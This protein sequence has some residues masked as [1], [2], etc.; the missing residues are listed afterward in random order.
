MAFQLFFYKLNLSSRGCFFGKL[1]IKIG[2]CVY[3][4]TGAATDSDLIEKAYRAKIEYLYEE[5]D[6]TYNQSKYFALVKWYSRPEELPKKNLQDEDFVFD[7]ERE[8]VVDSR[9]DNRIDIETIIKKCS[10]IEGGNFEE[11]KQRPDMYVCRYKLVRH[12]GKSQ[13]FDLLPLNAIISDYNKN[14]KTPKRTVSRAGSELKTPKLKIKR[15]SGEDFEIVD[16]IQSPS[17]KPC[18]IK[19]EDVS[20]SM[21]SLQVSP[22]KIVNNSVQKINRNRLDEDYYYVSPSKK[23]KNDYYEPNGNYL[24]IEEVNVDSPLIHRPS[25]AAKRRLTMESNAD[26]DYTITSEEVL[27]IKVRISQKENTQRRSSIEKTTPLRRSTRIKSVLIESEV[28]QE[29]E[30]NV[31]PRKNKQIDLGTPRQIVSRRKSILKTPGA[32]D[33]CT[34]KKTVVLTGI[35]EEHLAEVHRTPRRAAKQNEEEEITRTPRS[36]RK[37]ISKTTP[38]ST[39]SLT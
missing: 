12:P 38:K 2:D 23:S 10:V 9:A 19:L 11:I 37:S 35:V 6:S 20:Q 18:S 1:Q 17:T 30:N 4:Q 14:P 5:I 29:V 16:A 15:V 24:N 26:L 32:S 39:K 7:F 36:S 31:T 3:I 25:L 27:K 8:V 21:K 34:P 13:M 28:L 33:V 22:F